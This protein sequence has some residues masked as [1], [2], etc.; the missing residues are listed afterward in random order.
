M[1]P[2]QQKEAEA[3]AAWKDGS[4]VTFEDDAY[5][6]TYSPQLFNHRVKLPVTEHDKCGRTEILDTIKG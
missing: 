3:R 2:Y 5:F 4:K 6:R 1:T